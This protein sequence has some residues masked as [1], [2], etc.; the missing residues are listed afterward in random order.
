[1]SE[2]E[3]NEQGLEI[4]YEPVYEL[5][6]PGTA[7]IPVA[8]QRLTDKQ[9]HEVIGRYVSQAVSEEREACARIA[10]LYGA[11]SNVALRIAAAIRF[12]KG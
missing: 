11:A 6:S 4:V 12:R 5:N 10:D 9:L 7:A 3:Y 1:M 8:G 2:I